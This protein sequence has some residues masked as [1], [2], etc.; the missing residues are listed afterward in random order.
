MREISIK[1]LVSTS[2]NRKYNN[3]IGGKLLL[4]LWQKSKGMCR[5]KGRD[6]TLHTCQLESCTQG[7]IIICG[8]NLSTSCLVQIAMKRTCSRVVKTC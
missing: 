6:D 1:I 7:F 8:K 5:L 2:T 4:Y 3:G